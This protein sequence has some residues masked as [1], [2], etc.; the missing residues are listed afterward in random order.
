MPQGTTAATLSRV[1]YL[2]GLDGLRAL[3]VVGVMIYHANHDWLPGGFLGVEVFFVISGYLITLLLIGEQER[4]GRVDLTQFWTRRFRRLLPALYVLLALVAVYIAAFYSIA[5]EET[6]GDFMGGI[7]YVSNWYQIIVGQGYG[8]SEAFVPLRHLW[9]LAVEE[10]FY[11]LWP[12]VMVFLLRRSRGRLP[13]IGA[14]LLLVSVAIALVVAALFQ[15]GPVALSCNAEFHAGCWSVGGKYINVNDMLYLGSFSRAG[16]LMLGA[17]FAMLW[18]PMA[19]I[20]GPLRQK[21]RFL[22]L[23]ALGGLVLLVYLMGTMYLSKASGS[24]YNPWLFRGGFL[25]TGVATLLLVAAATHQLAATGQLLGNPLFRWIGT[26]SY[27][28]YLYHWPIY[29]IIRK[30]ANV[31]MSVAQVIAAMLIALPLTE[32]S[33][34]FIETPIRTGQFRQMRRSLTRGGAQALASFSVVALLGTAVYSLVSADPHCVGSVRCSLVNETTD[35]VTTDGASDTTLPGDTTTTTIKLPPKQYVAI[36]ESVME[37][38]YVY[39][40]TGGISTFA[41]EGLGPEGVKNS[42]KNRRNEGV[43]GTGTVIVIQVGHNAQISQP[44][45][46]AIMA[47]VPADAGQVWFMTVHGDAAWVTGNN[48]VIRAIPLKYPSVKLIDW[49]KESA[50]TKLCSDGMHL[51]CGK[52]DATKIFYTNVIL[53]ALGL[54]TV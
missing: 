32:I 49:D 35:P 27:G 8:S 12:L 47:E 31:Q 44:Q 22:D 1:P 37:G 2:P 15:S 26:R 9:S 50:G 3:A 5:R 11:L 36:G 14:K 51:T 48:A 23:L 29:Q 28:L 4:T 46:D 7:F 24:I 39:M 45:I 41:K 16:G 33:Y 19:V 30:Q 13:S 40:E 6:R 52:G 20:R 34:R 25:I 10:Q 54:P 38:A 17:G 18:R 53:K 42:V 43:I 21:G